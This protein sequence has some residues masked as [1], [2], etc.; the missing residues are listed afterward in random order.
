MITTIIIINEKFIYLN[1]FIITTMDKLKC[2]Y[3]NYEW[4]PRVIKPK[5]CPNCKK[6]NYEL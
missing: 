5:E 3:C 1:K 4:E 2:K 6:R